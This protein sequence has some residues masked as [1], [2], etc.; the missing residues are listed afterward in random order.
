MYSSTAKSRQYCVGTRKDGAR[1]AAWVLRDEP[2][3]SC[4]TH[5]GHAHCARSQHTHPLRACI[6]YSWP[7]RPGNDLC[8]WPDQPDYRGTTPVETHTERHRTI[9]R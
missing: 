5:V 3:P 6:A 8:Y 2:L 4:V 1:S 7:H 9:Q